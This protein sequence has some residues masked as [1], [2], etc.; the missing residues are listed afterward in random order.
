MLKNLAHS[1]QAMQA[2][3]D[4]R[5]IPSTDLFDKSEESHLEFDSLANKGFIII[6]NKQERFS[7]PQSIS[8]FT[9]SRVLKLEEALI[10]M[11]QVQEDGAK[12]IIQHERLPMAEISQK[13]TSFSF[14]LDADLIQSGEDYKRF[15]QYLNDESVSLSYDVMSDVQVVQWHKPLRA[16]ASY[17]EQAKRLLSFLKTTKFGFISL[18]KALWKIGISGRDVRSKEKAMKESKTLGFTKVEQTVIRMFNY[19]AAEVYDV[20]DGSSLMIYAQYQVQ[21][22]E[23]P[24]KVVLD[25]PI[26]SLNQL[27]TIKVNQIVT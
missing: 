14:V 17:A 20:E 8:S 21:D 15:S 2:W 26:G 6:K 12:W 25:P 11:I 10:A 16:N 23:N 22:V 13:N 19:S 5:G 9:T 3:N 27:L 7:V 24:F 18:Q 1:S 4:L